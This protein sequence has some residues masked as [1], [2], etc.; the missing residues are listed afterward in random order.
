MFAVA[1]VLIAQLCI[2]GADSYVKKK[3]HLFS[4]KH[5]PRWVG[6]YA[7]LRASGLILRLSAL[8]MLPVAAAATMFSSIAISTSSVVAHLH[9][10]KY[11]T[12]EKVAVGLVLGAVILRGLA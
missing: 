6:I 11:T 7:A 1:M 12:R 5:L 8:F 4:P 10:E 9:G 2:T 3:T